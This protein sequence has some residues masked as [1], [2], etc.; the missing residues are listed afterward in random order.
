MDHMAF[1]VNQDIVIVPIFYLENVLNQ[2]V[3]SQRFNEISDRLFPVYTKHLLIDLP[4][5]FLFGF[6]F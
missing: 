2:R 5:T 3:T 1:R 6:L 4:Q